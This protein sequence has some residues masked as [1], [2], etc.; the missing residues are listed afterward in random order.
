LLTELHEL[1][2]RVDATSIL[3]EDWCVT[4]QPARLAQHQGAHLLIAAGGQRT[5]VDG[6][7]ILEEMSVGLTSLKALD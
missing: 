4:R 7:E 5:T 3:E 6:V 1:V 2:D